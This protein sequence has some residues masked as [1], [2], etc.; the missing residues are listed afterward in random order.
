VK[1]WIFVEAASPWFS[2]H[3]VVR[4]RV[5]SCVSTYV[6]HST[7]TYISFPVAS[8]RYI[9]ESMGSVTF[10]LFHHRALVRSA[11]VRTWLF[12]SAVVHLKVIH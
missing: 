10:M 6:G 8:Y 7:H 1:V 4:G 9:A 12:G 5:S 3:P 2:S 11:S